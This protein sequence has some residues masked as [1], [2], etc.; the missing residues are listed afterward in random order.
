M[1]RMRNKVPGYFRFND[2]TQKGG[3]VE[4]LMQGEG[5]PRFR[6]RG[7]EQQ[8]F[9]VAGIVRTDRHTAIT[10]IKFY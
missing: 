7:A 8:T 1:V 3:R 6:R 4:Q 9:R 10:I 2:V 5:K